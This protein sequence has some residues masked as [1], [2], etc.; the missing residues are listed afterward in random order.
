V[1]KI[2]LTD[3]SLVKIGRDWN[4]SFFTNLIILCIFKPKTPI[5]IIV[6]FEEALNDGIGVCMI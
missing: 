2:D 5:P 4:G 1:I 3:Q 6:P